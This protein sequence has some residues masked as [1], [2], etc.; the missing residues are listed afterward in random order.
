MTNRL[1]FSV[2]LICLPLVGFCHGKLRGFIFPLITPI[3]ADLKFNFICGN[4]R[5]LRDKIFD[6]QIVDCYP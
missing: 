3:S 2:L 5:D 6:Y 4:L 1:I